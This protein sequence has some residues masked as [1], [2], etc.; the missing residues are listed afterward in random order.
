MADSDRTRSTDQARAA[1]LHQGRQCVGIIKRGSS[2]DSQGGRRAG[3]RPLAVAASASFAAHGLGLRRSSTARFDTQLEF[4]GHGIARPRPG[5]AARRVQRGVRAAGRRRTNGPGRCNS[6]G[7]VRRSRA[8]SD[9]SGS[10]WAIDDDRGSVRR[11]RPHRR[12]ILHGNGCVAPRV[13]GALL[14]ACRAHG[15][16]TAARQPRTRPCA[17]G[18]FAA[19]HRVW[20]LRGPLLEHGP[21]HAASPSSPDLSLED[22]FL[23][24]GQLDEKRTQAHE[25]ERLPKGDGEDAPFEHS[26][27]WAA[28][29]GA[30]LAAGLEARA[31]SHTEPNASGV[32]KSSLLCG[33]AGRDPRLDSRW[34]FASGNCPGAGTLPDLG[35]HAGS[36]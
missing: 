26:T 34:R 33:A 21:E 8:A 11:T 32:R 6:P 22:V 3:R 25:W 10:A 9:T 14:R 4:D 1:V 31:A 27:A 29:M 7:T 20:V 23:S 36:R 35:C 15:G 16:G 18:L 13:P 19:R 24:R 5:P 28:Q 2:R 12:S 30:R 17:R